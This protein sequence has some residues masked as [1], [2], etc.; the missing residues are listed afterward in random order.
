MDYKIL[1]VVF[2]SFVNQLWLRRD[3]KS[4]ICSN[5]FTNVVIKFR[6]KLD[7]QS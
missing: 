7:L 2:L 1:Y 3:L 4:V 6:S 5:S